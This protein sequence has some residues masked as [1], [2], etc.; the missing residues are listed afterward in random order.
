MANL[1]KSEEKSAQMLAATRNMN[2]TAA[3][4]AN[5]DVKFHRMTS[6]EFAARQDASAARLLNLVNILYS[7]TG[8][9][10]ESKFEL[11]M[12]LTDRWEE[13]HEANTELLE[14]ADLQLDSL[15]GQKENLSVGKFELSRNTLK[16]ELMHGDIPKPQLLFTET[17][18]NFDELPFKPRLTSKPN[19]I[20]SLADSLELVPGTFG[21]MM[22]VNPYTVEIEK[23]KYPKYV[24]KLC[25]PIEPMP[26]ETSEPI[27]VEDEA[28][29]KSMLKELA[30]EV[31]IAVDLEHNDTRSYIGL[32]SLMQIS[33]RSRDFLIDTLKLRGKLQILNKVFT[34]PK[35]VKV[36]HGAGSDVTWLQR[37]LGIYV[38]NLFDTFFG[39]TMLDFNKKSL[40]YLL[41]HYCDFDTNKKYQLADW[42]IRPLPEEMAYYARCDTHFL[43]YIFDRMRND[44]LG[45]GTISV[46]NKFGVERET[47]GIAEVL[48]ESRQLAQKS[49]EWPVYDEEYGKGIGGWLSISTKFKI[50]DGKQLDVLRALTRWRDQVSRAEDEGC[51]YIIPNRYIG[52]L[53]RRQPRDRAGVIAIISK[54]TSSS[55]MSRVD[56]ILEVIRRGLDDGI[57]I[58]AEMTTA[59]QEATATNE[60]E[61]EKQLVSDEMTQ[62][63]RMN[64]ASELFPE[65][66]SSKNFLV[67]QQPGS[68]CA[69]QSKVFGNL[70]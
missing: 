58:D 13:I 1:D 20:V 33:T 38:V 23:A 9:S 62:M 7:A 56:E 15:T 48:Q 3:E 67:G 57:A 35:I 27:W 59:G 60:Q 34:D 69:V 19:A 29:I 21:R 66:D 42:R 6:N 63:R 65:S 30:Q 4:L 49:Y 11:P 16:P 43:L 12:E 64:L 52:M 25:K 54:S 37:D 2:E 70:L 32:V 61:S 40:A 46:V 36:M 5:N 8:V 31:A 28:S 47:T 44:L 39:S 45:R 55:V 24:S 18:N 68:S 26:L 50:F 10:M 51:Q 17:I 14:K 22:Y 53:A 41:E